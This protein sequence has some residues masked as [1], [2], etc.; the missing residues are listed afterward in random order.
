MIP[1]LNNP[2]TVEDVH[3]NKKSTS[4]LKLKQKMK[5]LEFLKDFKNKHVHLNHHHFDSKSK[6]SRF[7][8]IKKDSLQSSSSSF[9]VNSLLLL[10]FCYT[11]FSQ[12]WKKWL[13]KTKTKLFNPFQNPFLSFLFFSFPLFIKSFS[14][15][16]FLQPS[17]LKSIH[18]Q[19]QRKN[20]YPLHKSQ[21]CWRMMM[22]GY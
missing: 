20:H 19:T 2:L 6:S 22:K 4:I 10:L 15:S 9:E 17:K 11:F 3:N 1:I 12:V 5:N 13:Q 21:W 7:S 16:Q 14:R 18:L 8:S